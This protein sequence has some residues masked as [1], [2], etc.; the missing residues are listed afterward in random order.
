MHSGD[1]SPISEDTVRSS[2]KCSSA[3]ALL[4]ENLAASPFTR[5]RP[6]EGLIFYQLGLVD[7]ENIGEAMEKIATINPCGIDINLG[8]PAP[9]IR[10]RGGGTELFED[11]DRLQAILAATRSRWRGILTVKCRLGKRTADWRERFA[12]RME[13]I[14]EAGVDAVIVHPRFAGEKLTRRARWSL[15]PWIASQAGLPVIGNGDIASAPAVSVLL[16][17]HGC[18]ACM[19]GRM[20]VVKPWIFREIP[21]AR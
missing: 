11:R 5:R 2:P 6:A 18:A 13:V 21:A 14:R 9:E 8:C 17:G 12:D 16:N 3:P 15:F 10:K 4:R 1:W 19:I 20:A 7:I